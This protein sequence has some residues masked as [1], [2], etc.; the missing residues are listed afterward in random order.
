VNRNSILSVIVA[1]SALL[2]ASVAGAQETTLQVGKFGQ[3]PGGPPD[4]YQVSTANVDWALQLVSSGYG[5]HY[6]R[7]RANA[8]FADMNAVV[9]NLQTTLRPAIEQAPKVKKVNTFL[10]TANPA[11]VR[12]EQ[13]PAGLRATVSGLKATVTADLTYS[14]GP[15]CSTLHGGFTIQ[16]VMT[17]EY[18]IATGLL[19]SSSVN[20]NVSNIHASCTGIFSDFTNLLISAFGGSYLRNLVTTAVQNAAT[21]Q[22]HLLDGRLIFSA[23]DFLEGLRVAGNYGYLNALANDVIN[24]GQSIVANPSGLS[25]GYRVD[26]YVSQAPSGNLVRILASHSSTASVTNISYPGMN[27]VLEVWRGPDIARVELV[28][29]YP[30]GYG[31]WYY[32][33]STTTDEFFMQG[34]LPVGTEFGAVG[35]STHSSNLRGDVSQTMISNFDPRCTHNCT[36]REI[37]E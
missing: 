8:M 26:F 3:N 21:D 15:F 28:Y 34:S 10:V 32:L 17:T 35:I 19:Q 6:T 24:I 4:A 23:H 5:A 13:T 7:D 33:G 36:P 25:N 9:T 14:A 16:P 31:N 12:I 20:A 27:T 29:R 11:N 2:S 18:S 30:A 1:S 22:L 37:E